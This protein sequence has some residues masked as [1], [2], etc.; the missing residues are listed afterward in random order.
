MVAIPEFPNARAVSLGD[1]PLIDRLL[2]Q[3]QPEISAYTFTNLFAWREQH[4]VSLS[5]VGDSLIVHYNDGDRRMC[6]RPLCGGDEVVEKVLSESQGDR[7]EFGYMPAEQA[8]RLASRPGLS[9]IEDRDNADYLYLARDLIDLAG[10]KYDAKRNFLGR[11][12]ANRSWQYLSITPANARDCIEFADEWCEDR[13][14][15]T[16]DGLHKEHCAVYQMLTN[17]GALGIVGGALRVDGRI[18]AFA[19]GERLNSET[20]VVHAEKADSGIEG[21]YQ[22]I[23]NQFCVHEAAGVT[24]VNREQDLGVP[25]LRKAK[26][27]YHPV[28]LVETYRVRRA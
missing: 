3:M 5:R 22:A 7:T 12:T 25:G 18:A 24:Y 26:L 17:F 4:R 9:V 16:A 10:R 23:N 27:S 2:A 28:K 1:K 11:F 19:L 20:L 6:L 13:S 15:E 14:C 8:S 21:A